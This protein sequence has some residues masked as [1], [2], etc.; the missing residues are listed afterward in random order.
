MNQ[1]IKTA[2]WHSMLEAEM[3]ARYWKHLLHRYMKRDTWLKIFLAAMAVGTVAAWGRWEEEME[4]LCKLLSSV[5]AIIAMSLPFLDYQRKIEQMSEVAG[6]WR[7]LRIEYQDLWYEVK[8]HPDSQLLEEGYRKIR[9]TEASFSGV[10]L[11]LPDDKAL[12]KKCFD[13][14]QR[15]TTKMQVP[16]L[17]PV[18]PEDGK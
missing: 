7:N 15:D 3:N 4:W 2:I 8:S 14:A 9:R 1:E 18:P 10:E 5:S 11:K 6:N 13:E 17:W 12:L 16:E